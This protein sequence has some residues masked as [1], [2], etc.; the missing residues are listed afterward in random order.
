MTIP[1]NVEGGRGIREARTGPVFSVDTKDGTLHMLYTARKHN[2]SWRDDSTTLEAVAFLEK[3]M[4]SKTPYIFLHRQDP[5]HGL[6][7]TNVLH[8]RAGFTDSAAK[9]RLIYRARY[10]DRIKGT[11]LAEVWPG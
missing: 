4:E 9:K 6:I 11:T 10:Y 5:G 3:L 1:A 7:S 2:V 8:D